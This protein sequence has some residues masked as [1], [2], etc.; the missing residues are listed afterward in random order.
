MKR[1]LNVAVF[2][3]HGNAGSNYVDTRSELRAGES[4]KSWYLN[5]EYK[6]VRYIACKQKINGQKV[7]LDTK[8][9]NATTDPRVS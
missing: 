6:G 8:P 7:Y 2:I 5:T 4:T 9:A 1:Y 3:S